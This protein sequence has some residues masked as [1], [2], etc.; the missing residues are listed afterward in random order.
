MSDRPPLD[1]EIQAAVQRYMATQARRYVP[2]AI[3]LAL[4]VAMIVRAPSRTEQEVE[5]AG[6]ANGASAPIE[7]GGATAPAPGAASPDAAPAPGEAAPGAGAPI[8]AGAGDVTG[9]GGAGAESEGGG[10]PGAAAAPPPGSGAGV[11]KT[12]VKC[13]PGVRQ[14]P[15]SRY[16]PPCV[17]A[18]EGDNGG[19]TAPGVTADTIVVSYR[20]AN[21]AQQGAINAASPNAIA[22]DATTIADMQRYVELFNKTFELYGRKV[23]LKPFQGQSDPLLEVQGQSQGPAQADAVRAKEVGAFA[24]V[25]GL[26]TQIYHE[27]LVDQ[28]IVAMGGI[29]M[30]Q[31]W[32]ADHAPYAYAAWFPT[33]DKVAKA[34]VNIVCQ[35]LNG[36]PAVD[37]GDPAM[38]KQQRV[39]GIVTPENPVYSAAG[40]IMEQ[41]LRKC[42]AKIGRR[43]KY[44]LNIATAQQ[45]A[46]SMI[47]QLKAAGVTT[48]VCGCDPIGP[49]F[50]SQAANTQQYRPEWDTLWWGDPS[51]RSVDSSQ[52]EHSIAIGVSGEIPPKERLEAYAAMKMAGA[53]PAQPNY[54]IPYYNLLQLFL[55]L[56]AAGPRL[57]PETFQQGLFSLPRS[58]DGNVGLWSFGPGAYT[59][60]TTYVISYWDPDH[61]SNFDGKKGGYVSCEGGRRFPFDDPAALGPKGQLRCFGR[62]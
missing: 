31:K 47:A 6:A 38:Q 45:Q 11:A 36:L 34:A 28:K 44:A 57:T 46:T 52:W 2:V 42:G 17:A 33:G 39:F 7:T 62:K 16:A 56:Q 3:A 29:Y 12:G 30:S 25:S 55:G 20:K 53:E 48:V 59:P 35:R 13:G 26:G 8:E 10:A 51:Q 24:D 5:S 54:P 21:S 50:F 58:E 37:A 27:A 61:T 4:V 14:F 60:Q 41:G 32:L 1:G 49:V 15:W 43:I 40:D 22:D 18:F 9:G 19:A 23:V